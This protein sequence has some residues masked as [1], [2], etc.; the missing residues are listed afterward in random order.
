MFSIMT[1][2]DEIFCF[3]SGATIRH[4]LEIFLMWAT[5]TFSKDGWESHTGERWE[6]AAGTTG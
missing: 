4:L 6:E 2:H 1:L 3:T 5:K